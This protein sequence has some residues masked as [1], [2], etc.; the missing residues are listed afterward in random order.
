M[1]LLY[2]NYKVAV[3]MIGRI[4][5][6]KIVKPR[7]P[8][9]VKTNME[10][11]SASWNGLVQRLSTVV[12]EGGRMALI[13]EMRRARTDLIGLSAVTFGVSAGQSYSLIGPGLAPISRT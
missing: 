6:R 3:F 2:Q 12:R 7:S 4:C 13:R 9:P 8:E 11:D 1:L 10:I 5:N